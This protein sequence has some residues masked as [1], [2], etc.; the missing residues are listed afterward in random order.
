[1]MIAEQ[2]Q[3]PG[4]VLGMSEQQALAVLAAS[5]DAHTIVKTAPPRGASE[6][7]AWRLA[8]VGGQPLRLT[9]CAFAPEKTA[10]REETP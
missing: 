6:A 10:A 9:F 5:G 3:S 1:M 8:H 2:A 7:S 4:V